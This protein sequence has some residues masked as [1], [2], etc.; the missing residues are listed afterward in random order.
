MSVGS[1]ARL[2]TVTSK[3]CSA[4]AAS[5]SVAVTV[6]VAVPAAMAVTVSALPDTATVARA[7]SEEAAE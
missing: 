5:G 2:G 1:G 7:V 3:V 4:L 6:I